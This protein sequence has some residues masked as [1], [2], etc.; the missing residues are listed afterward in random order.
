V[1]LLAG[2]RERRHLGEVVVERDDAR[3]RVAIL[4][5]VTEA[6][7]GCVRA[8]VLD[9]DEIGAADV[10]AG[11]AETVDRLR[12]HVD[13]ARLAEQATRCQ[14]DTL[15]FAERERDYLG[16][17]DDEL[18]RIISVL[19]DGLGAVAASSASY[20]QRLLARAAGSRPRRGSTIW[21]RSAPRSPP[22]CRRY[23]PTSPSARSRSGARRRRCAPRSRP[24]A[25]VAQARTEARTD[26]L[27]GAANRAAFDDELARCQLAT[28]GGDGFALIMVDVDHF[29]RVNDEH[30]HAVGDRVL[31]GLVAFLRP[32]VRRDDLIARWG[33]EEFAVVLPGASTRVALKKARA[34]LRE[35]AGTDWTID[36]GRTIRFTVSAGVT[37][38]KSGDAPDTIT[39]RADRALYKAKHAG[40]NRAER[41]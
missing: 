13:P 25:S 2:L 5:E 19:T 39:A 40:R 24:C 18:R 27:T 15:T 22:R 31:T 21:S 35:L 34:V 32:R 6:M 11:L 30:G 29:K 41:G 4:E 7:L 26:P 37:A 36:G 16:R 38:W 1:S 28:A 12:G 14:H 23:G 10:R 3:E 9:L 33:G 8:L 20:H 17:R